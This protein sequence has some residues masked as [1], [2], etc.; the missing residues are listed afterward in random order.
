M[1]AGAV[2]AFAAHG[3][4]SEAEATAYLVKCDA[5]VSL[6]GGA[7]VLKGDVVHICAKQEGL[8]G[9][10]LVRGVRAAL[11]KFHI[12]RATL[13]CPI[14]HDNRRA[15]EFAMHFGFTPYHSTHTHQWLFRHSGDALP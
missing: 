15:M 14:R 13:K 6:P 11:L 8:S 3:G 9:R 10:A 1:N 4:I 12:L 5:V 7:I 2:A